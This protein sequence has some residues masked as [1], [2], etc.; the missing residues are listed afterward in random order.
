MLLCAR[1]QVFELD[2]TLF[3]HNQEESLDAGW[4][5]AEPRR[6]QALCRVCEHV[7]CESTC[8]NVQGQVSTKGRWCLGSRGGQWGVSGDQR[9]RVP[10][11]VTWI[12]LCSRSP[13][14]HEHL[15]IGSR[16][17]YLITTTKTHAT[18]LELPCGLSRVHA[19]ILVLLNL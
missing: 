13:E 8:V 9:D 17:V 14:M 18:E 12:Q 7:L 6:H 5:T 19:V 1:E 3:S 10:L 15:D 11:P 4:N 2:G 16:S